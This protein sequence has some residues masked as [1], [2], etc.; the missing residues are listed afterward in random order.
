MKIK[1]MYTDKNLSI[2]IPI[3]IFITNLTQLPSLHGSSIGKIILLFCW[4]GLLLYLIFN[5][6]SIL[7]FNIFGVLFLVLIFDIYIILCQLITSKPYITSNFIYPLHLS[8][9]IFFVSYLSGQLMNIKKIKM[10]INSYFISCLFVTSIIY[11]EFFKGINW[12]QESGYIYTSKNSIS[13]IVLTCIILLIVFKE[14]GIN[15]ILKYLSLIFF[16]IFLLMIKSRAAILALIFSIAYLILFGVK[17]KVKKTIL[18]FAFIAVIL[19]ILINENLYELFINQIILNNREGSDLNT[20]SSGRID[21][22]NVFLES[23]HL[24]V[25]FGNG[26]QYLESFPLT[27]LLSYGLIGGSLVILI[28]L[29]PFYYLYIKYRES[30]N[31]SLAL[32]T[33]VI[34]LSI[35]INCLFEELPPFGP[36]VKCYVLWMLLGVYIGN[37]KRKEN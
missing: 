34:Y 25:W 4:V 36:G 3:I 24:N 2:L 5:Y 15:K 8:I 17:D 10:L 35:L 13:Q 26:G 6:M 11:V 1:N 12:S 30:Y 32:A 20:I 19:F 21:H 37:K 23:F 31:T 14:S 16:F 27:V 18:V 22:L 9:F 28:A 7:K 29:Y 33:K